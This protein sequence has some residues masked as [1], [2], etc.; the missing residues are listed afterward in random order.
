MQL[1]NSHAAL[2][3][4]DAVVGDMDSITADALDFYVKN[5]RIYRLQYKW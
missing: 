2:T 1:Y 4:P 3:L 5:V